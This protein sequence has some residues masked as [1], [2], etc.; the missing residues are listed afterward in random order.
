MSYTIKV[1]T[2]T[3]VII[4]L[5]R[6]KNERSFISGFKRYDEEFK[7]KNSWHNY[8][9]IEIRSLP[10]IDEKLFDIKAPQFGNPVMQRANFMGT[11]FGYADSKDG[12]YLKAIRND[13]HKTVAAGA[14]YDFKSNIQDMKNSFYS[15]M[16]V[17]LSIAIIS[18]VVVFFPAS[19][20]GLLTFINWLNSAAGTLV[21]QNITGILGLP[22]N[23]KTGLLA[24]FMVA[25][26]AY[27]WNSRQA[28][29]LYGAL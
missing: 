21:E 25:L 23:F 12:K 6:H 27:I 16:G 26:V 8:R 13:S 14:G 17:G 9:K 2:N 15:V 20:A 4:C 18:A 22:G 10:K 7:W 24:S 11:N 29:S 28:E 19:G 1:D 3:C 5:R